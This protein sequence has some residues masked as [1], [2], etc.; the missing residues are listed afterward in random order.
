MD[1]LTPKISLWAI[2]ILLLALVLLAGIEE[3]RISNWRADYAEQ[4]TELN[5]AQDDLATCRANVG[6]LSTAIAT[7]NAKIK[8]MQQ[9]AVA[10]QADRDA[11]ARAAMEARKDAATVK[12][13]GPAVMNAW[14]H[15]EYGVNP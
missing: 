2:G 7:Q 5:N 4:K 12:G 9:E 15:R 14:F 8:V 3:L 13:F 6:T 11:Q 10:L 1:F